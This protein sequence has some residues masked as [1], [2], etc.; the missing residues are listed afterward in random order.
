MYTTGKPDTAG[1]SIQECTY[2]LKSV[3]A[4]GL[5]LYIR[6]PRRSGRLGVERTEIYMETV[7][8]QRPYGIP[9]GSPTLREA[10]YKD[11]HMH[12]S[13]SMPEALLCV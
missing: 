3:H 1:R 6:K 10:L 12:G 9:L 2:T 7:L 4:G 8:S 5:I 11:L 13:R